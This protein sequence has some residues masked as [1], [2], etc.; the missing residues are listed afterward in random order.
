M[1]A[2]PL[3]RALRPC[4]LTFAALQA[5]LALYLTGS[6]AERVPVMRMLRADAAA[7]EGRARAVANRITERCGGLVDVVE[8]A[9]RV[10]GGAAPER[11]LPSRGL[12]LRA[13]GLSADA[14]AARMLE[15]A[16]PLVA[17]IND[18][19]VLV[20]LRTIPPEDDDALVSCITE[21]LTTNDD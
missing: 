1:R 16:K 18:G 10:G 19:R 8:L 20:D 5:T 4:K 21:A 17:R 9:S 11:T 7:L 15:C 6:A 3:A 12:E 2:N 13:R 14:L